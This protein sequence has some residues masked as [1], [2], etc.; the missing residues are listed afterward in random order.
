MLRKN[1]Q[2]KDA[3]LEAFSLLLYTIYITLNKN[4]LIFLGLA[5]IKYGILQIE[6]EFRTHMRNEKKT[7][8]ML[9]KTN[10]ESSK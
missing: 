5:T 7:T 2:N 4:T 6:F 9:F 8:Y 10:I 1:I 3:L